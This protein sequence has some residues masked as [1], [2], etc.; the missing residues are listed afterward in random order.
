MSENW[1]SVDVVERTTE[2]QDITSVLLA[3]I[4]GGPLPPFEAGAHIDVETPSGIIRQYSLCGSPSEAGRYRIGVLRDPSSRG[5]S[6]SVHD[7]VHIG[8]RLRVSKPKNH[9]PLVPEVMKLRTNGPITTYLPTSTDKSLLVAGGIG[10]TPIL[11]MA[12]TLSQQGRSFELHYCS[13]T[14]ERTAFVQRI[15][16]S[17]FAKN[18]QFHFDDGSADQLFDVAKVLENPFSDQHL[19]VCGPKGLMDAVINTAKRLNWNPDNVHF[20]YFAAV[21]PSTSGG[22]FDVVLSKSGKVIRVVEG[23]TVIEALR[24][25]DVD[26][27][28]SC[29]QGVCGTCVTRVLEGIP[30]HRDLYLT[31]AEH[32]KNDQFTP[33][34]SRSITPCL[35][36]DL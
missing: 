16:S 31:D 25:N 35:V 36:L 5:G 29:E 8:T 27:P 34:C 11:A 15:R 24:Q 26:V 2:A 4:G 17:S 32:A 28:V 21:A 13:R 14:I 3:D 33:C 10:V 20:E 23:V 7:D 22:D 30:D 6:K 18:V 19:Y 12:E 9:F 1:L